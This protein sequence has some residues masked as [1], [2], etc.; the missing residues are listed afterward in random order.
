LYAVDTDGN[1]LRRLTN[2]PLD[3]QHARWS[4]DGHAILFTHHGGLYLMGPDGSNQ[5]PLGNSAISGLF[6]AW[7]PCDK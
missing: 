5:R 6:A 3:D 7:G 2:N 4:P 1:N